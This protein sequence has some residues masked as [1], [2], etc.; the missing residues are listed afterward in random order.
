MNSFS[1]SVFNYSCSYFCSKAGLSYLNT[2]FVCFF[3]SCCECFQFCRLPYFKHVQPRAPAALPQRGHH[4]GRAGGTDA[5]I[6]RI[7]QKGWTQEGRLAWN[8]VWSVENWTD[9]TNYGAVTEFIF[10]IIY[11]FIFCSVLIFT[12]CRL[13]NRQTY[14]TYKSEHTNLNVIN[15]LL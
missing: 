5:A 3:R 6:C 13:W 1:F 9:G 10:F 11:F 4:R 2:F 15:L 14:G 12:C 7:G 8:S